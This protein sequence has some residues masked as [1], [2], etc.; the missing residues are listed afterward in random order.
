MI[1]Y[2]SWKF[3]QLDNGET[4]ILLNGVTFVE[5]AIKRAAGYGAK[6]I[7]FDNDEAGEDATR[8][9]Q[10]AY[11]LTHNGANNY[12]GF[13]DYNQRLTSELDNLY[14]LPVADHYS[15]AKTGL[16]R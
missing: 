10:H 16:R 8:T 2:L 6:T 7:F 14:R 5:A 15:Q 11:P 12:A 9:F 1:D 3:E 13:K 4:V